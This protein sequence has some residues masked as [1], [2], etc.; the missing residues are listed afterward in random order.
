MIMPASHGR[1]VAD[2]THSLTISLHTLGNSSCH[3]MIYGAAKLSRSGRVVRSFGWGGEAEAGGQRKSLAMSTEKSEVRESEE[4]EEGKGK[5]IRRR[6][7]LM[8][9]RG[10]EREE[11]K[12]LIYGLSRWALRSRQLKPM[13]RN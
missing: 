10:E 9:R 2:T 12:R 5:F 11:I 4:K 8:H 3:D 7:R 6:R 13:S 1:V